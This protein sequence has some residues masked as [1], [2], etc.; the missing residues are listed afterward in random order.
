MQTVSQL[1][2]LGGRLS[3]EGLLF[4]REEVEVLK[5]QVSG[6]KEQRVA[7]EFE[8][9]DPKQKIKYLEKVAEAS[10]ADALAV[11]QKNQELEE[12]IEALR[13]A[14]ETFKFEM[15]MAVNGARVIARWEL[16]R[17]WLRKQSAQLDLV[18]ALEQYMSVVREEARRKGAPLPTFEDEP[19]IPPSSDM[20]MDSSVKPRGSPT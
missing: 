2:H 20:D 7:W 14:A 12:D 5:H 16:M 9:R 11:N 3:D 19:A 10:S 17:K 1:H 18:T 6:E 13:A 15:V 8:I 4:L